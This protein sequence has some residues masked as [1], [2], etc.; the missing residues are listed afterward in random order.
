MANLK[1]WKR[2][3]YQIYLLSFA[4]GVTDEVGDVAPEYGTLDDFRRFLDSVYSCERT[5]KK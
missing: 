1:L 4:D 2:V 5:L 3:F